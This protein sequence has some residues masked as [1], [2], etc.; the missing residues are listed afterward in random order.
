MVLLERRMI[1]LL[2]IVPLVG[3]AEELNWRGDGSNE[4]SDE[5][6]WACGDGGDDGFFPWDQRVLLE[7][8][9]SYHSE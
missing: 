6:D 8:I 1:F 5:L 9:L 2:E 4:G 3:L 7:L